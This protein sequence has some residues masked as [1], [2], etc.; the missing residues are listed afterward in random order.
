MRKEGNKMLEINRYTKQIKVTR[1]DRVT[2]QA[3]PLTYVLDKDGNKVIGTGGLPEVTPYTFVTGDVATLT[4]KKKA[5]KDS[6]VIFKLTSSDGSFT[7]T[8]DLTKDLALGDYKYDISL[9]SA[10]GEPYNYI[11]TPSD[12]SPTLTI[13]EVTK[14]E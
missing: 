13:M 9:T 11:R 10:S 3:I 6:P 7:I 8:S 14:E 12:K 2:F 4:V 5:E 1:G